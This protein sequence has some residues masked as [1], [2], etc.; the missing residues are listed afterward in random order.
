MLGIGKGSNGRRFFSGLEDS[1][2]E[3]IFEGF[4]WKPEYLLEI[5]GR[6][7]RVGEGMIKGKGE[8]EGKGQPG[9]MS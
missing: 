8:G 5:K 9:E 3:R 1:G 2:D 7:N 6:F 4:C